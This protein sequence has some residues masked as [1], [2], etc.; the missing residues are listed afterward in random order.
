MTRYTVV[1]DEAVD[2]HFLDAWIKSD[3]TTRAVLSDFATLVDRTL[4]V[5]AETVGEP[6]STED[7]RAVVIHVAS[8]SVTVHFKVL[9]ADRIARVTRFVFRPSG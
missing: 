1:W 2:A 6:Q 3:A 4:S 5:N 7:M 9:P 8:A